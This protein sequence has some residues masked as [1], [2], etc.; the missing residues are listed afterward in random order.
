MALGALLIDEFTVLHAATTAHYVR[1]DQETA[2]QLVGKFKDRVDASRL[3]GLD[4]EREL[5]D[6]LYSRISFLSGHGGEPDPRIGRLWGRWQ[7]VGG[8]ENTGYEPGDYLEFTADNRLLTFG[9]GETTPND[10]AGYESNAS[11]ILLTESEMVFR[12]KVRGDKL[13]LRNLE[14]G[15]RLELKRMV[16]RVGAAH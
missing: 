1:N 8:S 14:D 16:E 3:G 9:Q 6:S 10:E 15:E 2:Y 13:T 12:Y 4:G 7:V 5:I 11:Q